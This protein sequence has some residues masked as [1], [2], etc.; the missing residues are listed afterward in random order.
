MNSNTHSLINDISKGTYDSDLE[1]IAEYIRFRQKHLAPK[2]YEFRVGQRVWFNDKVRPTYMAGVAATITKIN[3]K[4]VKVRLDD[5]TGRFGTGDLTCPTDF[6][7]MKDP[8]Q[9]AQPAV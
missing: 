6:L 9:Q 8:L 2:A 7:S 5:R 3:Q 4:K 1:T